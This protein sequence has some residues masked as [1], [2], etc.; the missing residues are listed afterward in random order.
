MEDPTK[1][2]DS[3]CHREHSNVRKKKKS[4]SVS[5]RAAAAEPVQQIRPAD[6]GQQPVF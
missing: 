5:R 4:L 1:C 2:A 6:S 3:N